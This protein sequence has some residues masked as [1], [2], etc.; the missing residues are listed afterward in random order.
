LVYLHFHPGEYRSLFL[1][2]FLPAIAGVGLLFFIKEKKNATILTQQKSF[3]KLFSFLS[4][5]KKSSPDY[6]HAAGG[7]I[8][9]ALFNSSDAFLLIRARDVGAT[10]EQVIMAYIFYN[11][12]Y[13]LF[14]FP[15]GT[16]ADRMGMKKTFLLGLF[17]FIAAYTGMAFASSASHVF[18]LFIL[19]GIYAAIVET[20]SKAWLSGLCEKEERA[21]AL[22]FYSGITSL[23][24]LAA[25]G[26]AGLIWVKAGAAPVFIFAATG[27]VLV[28]F[29]F[30]LIKRSAH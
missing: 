22:G 6:K 14:A 27:T 23:M 18:A 29:Y 28:M 16:L 3:P 21:T 15:A 1:Y 9:F 17:F 11:L 20:V 19:Y 12:I 10:D 24:A 8:A 13:A 7:L 5:W 4:Y 25:S 2:A 30:S 26:I